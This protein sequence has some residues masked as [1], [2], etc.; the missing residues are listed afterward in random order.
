MYYTIGQRQ[1]LH[2]GGRKQAQAK[3][4][5][6]V[7][8]DLVRNVLIV[9]QGHDHPLLFTTTLDCSQTS[10]VSGQAPALPFTCMAKTRYRQAEQPC[11]IETHT[12]NSY[13]VHFDTPQWAVTPG[14]S[15]VFYQDDKCLGGGIIDKSYKSCRR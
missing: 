8:K 9:A 10:W 1:G 12:E 3:P 14:Q 6:A 15:I 11:I 4:W 5:Y 7:G 2:I 13:R